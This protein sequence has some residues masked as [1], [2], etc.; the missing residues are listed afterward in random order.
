M[1]SSSVNKLTVIQDTPNRTFKINYELSF[2][3]KHITGHKH[4]QSNDINPTMKI[5]AFTYFLPIY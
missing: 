3:K 1:F 5:V 4:D 2:V